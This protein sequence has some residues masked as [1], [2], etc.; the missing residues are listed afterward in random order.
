MTPPVGPSGWERWLDS[1]ADDTVILDSMNDE[2]TKRDGAWHQ[3]DT[4]PLGAQYMAK[5]YAPFR[6]IK[7]G[8]E[9]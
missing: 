8:G 6:I 1:L 9:A 3:P 7:A 5:H 2:V 4:I